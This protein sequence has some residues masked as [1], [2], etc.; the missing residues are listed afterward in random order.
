M[1]NPNDARRV[2]LERPTTNGSA[3]SSLLTGEQSGM[4]GGARR[5]GG[6]HQSRH[7]PGLGEV[8]PMRSGGLREGEARAPAS[9]HGTHGLPMSR[10]TP[11]ESSSKQLQKPDQHE[12]ELERDGDQSQG[13]ELME[14]TQCGCGRWA[15]VDPVKLPP[16]DCGANAA[17]GATPFSPEM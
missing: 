14:Y 5:G 4:E 12:G 6:R 10:S 7:P 2:N 17:E 3:A 1:Y 13:A 9:A 8:H 11:L 15:G 16:E